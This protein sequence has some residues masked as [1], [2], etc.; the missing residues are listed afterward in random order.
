VRTQ[1]QF[2]AERRASWNELDALLMADRELHKLAPSSISRAAAL[3]RSVCADLMHARGAGYTNDLTTH[4]DA[5]AARAHNALYG[6]RPWRIAGAWQLVAREFPRTLR[7]RWR[8]FALAA[9]AFGLP[10]LAGLLAALESTELAER[11]LPPQQLAAMAQMYAEGFEGRA[12]GTDATMAGFYVHNNVGIAFRCF[13]TGILLGLGS[14][15]FLVYNG[16]VIGATTGHVI[17]SG[18]GS[19]ILTFMCGH[20]VF[21]LTAIVISGGAGLQMGYA[22]VETHGRT[23]LGSL[24]SQSHELAQL[25]LGAALMLLIAAGLEGFW[26]PS[27]VAPVIKWIAAGVFAV[28]LASWLALGGRRSDRARVGGAT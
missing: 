7:K 5:I 21:E 26:S 11:I 27:G 13:A 6:A 2:I 18:G 23:R 8:F 14:L 3:Y 17:V 12:E 16:L 4:L 1:D 25:I 10:L 22:L 24:R 9:A 28:L 19:N 20:G 15:F